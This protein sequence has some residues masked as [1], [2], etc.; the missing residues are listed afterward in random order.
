M[1]KKK[2]IMTDDSSVA[3]SEKKWGMPTY[4]RCGIHDVIGHF[5]CQARHFTSC[6]AE[7]IW[8]TEYIA[9]TATQIRAVI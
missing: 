1:C 9:L 8:H 6:S 5:R 2:W 7:V 3:G 4:H